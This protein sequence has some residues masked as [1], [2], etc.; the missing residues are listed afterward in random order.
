ME[1]TDIILMRTIDRYI[2]WTIG[3]RKLL[4]KKQDKKQQKN[5]DQ[6]SFDEIKKMWR[7]LQGFIHLF[8]VSKKKTLVCWHNP[9]LF[10]FI[11]IDLVLDV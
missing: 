8:Y 10:D 4:S 7:V 1:T 6:R 11:R 3:Y 9:H 2:M 5:I